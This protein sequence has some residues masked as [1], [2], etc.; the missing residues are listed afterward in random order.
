MQKKI[1][2]V[3]PAFKDGSSTEYSNG[4]WKSEVLGIWVAKFQAGIK[5]TERDTS[6]KISNSSLTVNNYYYPVF[7][8]RKY[9]YNYVGES[10]S[11]DTVTNTSNEELTSYAWTVVDD[12]TDKG[13][14]TKS[15]TTGNIYGIFDMS[16][17]LAECTAAYVNYLEGNEYGKVFATG[18]STYL[19]T[20]YPNKSTTNM[21]FNSAYKAEVFC[22]IYGDAIWETTKYVGKELAWFG[23]TQEDD[24][25]STEI[26]FPRG[27]NL[28]NSYYCDFCVK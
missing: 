24:N 27:G 14:G 2:V 6:T 5:T 11:Y 1:Y 23:D 28:W 9:G 3:H 4:E 26:F 15:S 25:G 21:D 8:G 7:K 10:Q 13:D 12:G 18:K 22:H 16:C 17:S 20:A 19:S